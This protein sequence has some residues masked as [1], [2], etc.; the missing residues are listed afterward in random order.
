MMYGDIGQPISLEGRIDYMVHGASRSSPISF[1]ADPIDTLDA[2]VNGTRNLLEHARKHGIDQFLFISSSEV[3][4]NP[5]QD[6]IPTSESYLGNVD[7]MGDMACYAEGKRFSE[8]LCSIFSRRHNIS[9]KSARIF[10]TFGPGLRNDGK[11][12]ANMFATGI[13]NRQ[14][15][16]R[17]QGLARRS[18][19]YVADTTRGILDILFSGK[20]GEAYNVGSDNNFTSVRELAQKVSDSLKLTDPV[21]VPSRPQ[22]SGGVIL[23]RSPD[24]TKIKQLG[25]CPRVSIDGAVVRLKDHILEA[26]L[27]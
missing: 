22:V 19:A 17:D 14:I 15:E 26:G 4:G 18:Y 7:N 21:I 16:L 1:K 20:S 24:L 13:K 3:Y 25:Y 9:T 5:P 10:Y 11:T 6:Q 8:T 23:D 2:N 27:G 12:L